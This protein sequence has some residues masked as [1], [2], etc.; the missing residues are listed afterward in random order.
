MDEPSFPGHKMGTRPLWTP[1]WDGFWFKAHLDCCRLIQ[2]LVRNLGN[3]RQKDRKHRE[4]NIRWT[5][6]SV[7]HW[8]SW[9]ITEP[10]FRVK[11]FLKCAMNSDGLYI[12]CIHPAS[13]DRTERFHK[14][15]NDMLSKKTSR[16]L[17]MWDQYLPF[18]VQPYWVGISELTRQ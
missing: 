17:E 16:H 14:V 18:I 3:S 9:Q 6:S 1:P 10:S 4:N 11:L 5:D 12:M 7:L 15:M 13:N 2:W 8:K